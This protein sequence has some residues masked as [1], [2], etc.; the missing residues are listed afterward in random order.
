MAQYTLINPLQQILTFDEYKK[1]LK[2]AEAYMEKNQFSTQEKKPR[3]RPKGTTKKPQP[4]EPVE[5]KK[6]GRPPKAKPE[7]P[8]PKA[9]VGRPAKEPNDYNTLFDAEF[10]TNDFGT[11]WFEDPEAITK[12]LNKY[13][14][15]PENQF[16]KIKDGKLEKYEDKK[17]TVISSLGKQSALDLVSII[18][19]RRLLASHNS[20]ADDYNLD[21]SKPQGKERLTRLVLFVKEYIKDRFSPKV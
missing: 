11:L 4:I 19:V 2:K 14:K 20:P 8:A 13:F 3:G 1:A 7:T 5:P 9:P 16:I 15:T 12:S 21:K 18:I 6:R 17:W 10:D